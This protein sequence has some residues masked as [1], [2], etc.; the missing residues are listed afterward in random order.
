MLKIE[1]GKFS[2]K[3]TEIN[4]RQRMYKE[5]SY[6]TLMINTEF[7]IQNSSDIKIIDLVDNKLQTEIKEKRKRFHDFINHDGFVQK[8]MLKIGNIIKDKIDSNEFYIIISINK[9]SF[10]CLSLNKLKR[11]IIDIK[12]LK[13]Y[14]TILSSKDCLYEIEWF[15]ENK[16]F[17]LSD[18]Y[19]RP[20]VK[21]IG[22]SEV[23]KYFVKE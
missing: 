22:N 16:N 6:I 11:G 15:K 14:D 5:K 9:K 21:S 10:E 20:V 12:L 2:E 18:F 8:S 3:F 19:D 1:K 23:R 7:K 13:K 17:D 4:I